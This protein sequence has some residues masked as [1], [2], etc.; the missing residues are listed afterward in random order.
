MA[1]KGKIRPK[2]SKWA[3]GCLSLAFIASVLVAA[4]VLHT[5]VRDLTASYTGIGLNPFAGV[6]GDPQ[7]SPPS[8]GASP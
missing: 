2:I 6:I 7:D 1:E 8:P 3:V 4:V 5:T